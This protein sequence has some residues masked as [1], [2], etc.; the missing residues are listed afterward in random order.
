M[1]LAVNTS[2]DWHAKHSLQGQAIHSSA[3]YPFCLMKVA[4]HHFRMNWQS[5]VQ[6]HEKARLKPECLQ[7][8]LHSVK[9][10][11]CV[12]SLNIRQSKDNFAKSIWQTLSNL[13]SVSS[14]AERGLSESALGGLLRPCLWQS[15]SVYVKPCARNG[16]NPHC[17]RWPAGE[18]TLHPWKD[19]TICHNGQSRLWSGREAE[20]QCG[21]VKGDLTP[22]GC[23]I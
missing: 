23:C 21:G 13:L 12:R 7:T 9:A 10:S 15:P 20:D 11:A 19:Q 17:E 22:R 18:W 8:T 4:I 16:A 6:K 1:L 14:S 2:C 5:C 3:L